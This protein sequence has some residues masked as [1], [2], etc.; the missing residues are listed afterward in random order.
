M[1]TQRD[2]AEV[3]A[4]IGP[5]ASAAVPAIIAL[6]DDPRSVQMVF[7]KTLGRIGPS[8]KEAVP[9][10]EKKL[11][12]EDARLRLTAADALTRIVPGQCSN[13]IAVLRALQHNPEFAE[14]WVST[15][16][17]SAMKKDKLDFDNQLSRFYRLSAAVPLWKLGLENQSPAAAILKELQQTPSSDEF[18]YIELLGDLGPEAKAAL[19]KL[20]TYLAPDKWIALRRKAAIAI[21]KIDP[22]E[23]N[24]LGLPGTLAVPMM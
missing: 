9:L 13:A 16:H 5:E 24:R 8:A 6:A 21:Q 15:G 20:E 22:A 7:S 4:E 1:N 17:G 10:L 2:I 19:P 18:A 12:S 23:A 3:L 11:G 14:V